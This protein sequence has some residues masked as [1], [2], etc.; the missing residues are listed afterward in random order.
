MRDRTNAT[1]SA[2]ASLG[3]R[4]VR[5]IEP[6][7][8]PVTTP[9]ED[10]TINKNKPMGFSAPPDLIIN[11]I[12]LIALPL[13]KDVCE[14]GKIVL[15]FDNTRKELWWSN[16]AT[17][18]SFLV[19]FGHATYDYFS[20]CWG[21]GEIAIDPTNFLEFLKQS[22][23][24]KAEQVM[25]SADPTKM[26]YE[27]KQDGTENVF[28]GVLNEISEINTHMPRIDYVKNHSQNKITLDDNYI[29]ILREEAAALK[30]GGII[31]ASDLKTIVEMGAKFRM[32]TYPI[33]FTPNPAEMFVTFKDDY[34]PAKGTNKKKIIFKEGTMIPPDTPISLV[35]SKTIEAPA[36]VLKGDVIL[37]LS[38]KVKAPVYLLKIEK[39][40][41]KPNGVMFAGMLMETK[42]Q[43]IK[44]I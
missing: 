24:E 43:Q 7:E 29:P 39:S 11:L 8:N 32:N 33:D 12:N 38:K 18:G 23:K 2:L 19:N 36:K 16:K 37:R 40:E 21:D 41:V 30:Y 28:E 22:K 13:A 44:V 31:K 6:K 25:F 1:K 9:V 10:V 5:I 27:L 26:N 4:K 14:F 42:A 20:D 17:G 3:L 35:L 15:H 34:L